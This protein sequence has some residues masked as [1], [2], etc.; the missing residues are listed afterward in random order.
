MS[1][2]SATSSPDKMGVD[3]DDRRTSFESTD[4]VMAPFEHMAPKLRT[5]HEAKPMPTVA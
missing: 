4:D 2:S 1:T 5:V 3:K